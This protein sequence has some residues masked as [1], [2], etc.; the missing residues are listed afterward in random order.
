MKIRHLKD[1]GSFQKGEIQKLFFE[2]I[3]QIV[4]IGFMGI[5]F[6]FIPKRR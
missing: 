5:I 2:N 1:S 4:H 3:E 6:G